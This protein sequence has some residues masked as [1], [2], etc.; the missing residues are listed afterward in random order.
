MGEV[1]GR[2]GEGLRGRC[3]FRQGQKCPC[4]F[5][6]L[7]DTIRYIDR[8]LARKDHENSKA[9]TICNHIFAIDFYLLF[10]VRDT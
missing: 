8:N 5:L 9:E 1:P 7:Y 2:G 10:F 3:E 4:F 6:Y